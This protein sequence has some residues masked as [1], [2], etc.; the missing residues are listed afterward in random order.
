MELA[1]LVPFVPIAAAVL[2]PLARE[3]ADFRRSWGLT[4]TGALLTTFLVVPAF[5]LGL[6]V[7]LPLAETPAAHWGAIVVVTLI[8]YSVGTRVALAAAQAPAASERS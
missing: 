4:R 1:N 8:A 3:Y 6:A 5:V 7:A 2:V